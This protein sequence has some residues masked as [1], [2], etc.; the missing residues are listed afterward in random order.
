[1]T[2]NHTILQ[3][4]GCVER[5]FNAKDYY[6]KY[7]DIGSMDSDEEEKPRAKSCFI[8]GQK[9]YKNIDYFRIDGQVSASKRTNQIDNFNN[10]DDER[11]RYDFWNRT[12]S[13]I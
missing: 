2:H 9:W 11:A 12:F 7:S 10:V 1:V 3:K 6:S 13:K 8:G 4:F 5:K